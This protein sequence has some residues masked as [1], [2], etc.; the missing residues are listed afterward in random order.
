MILGF[1]LPCIAG[2]WIF[3]REPKII[4]LIAPI[5]ST[6]AFAINQWGFQYFWS[7][8]PIYKNISLS[9]FPMDIGLYPV[10]ACLYIYLILKTSISPLILAILLSLGLTF[11][12]WTMVVTD[13]VLYFNNWNILATFFSY[14][15]WYVIIYS[16]FRI[17]KTHKII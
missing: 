9:A 3:K 15:F 4:L 7:V 2:I 11:L 6:T 5:G 13:R 17:L 1:I 8:K 12:E 16:Y 14:A 10:F